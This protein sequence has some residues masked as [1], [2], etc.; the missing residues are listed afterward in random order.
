MIHQIEIRNQHASL[1]IY[2]ERLLACCRQMMLVAT[3][4]AQ[5]ELLNDTH[6]EVMLC[7]QRIGGIGTEIGRSGR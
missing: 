5:E 1:L 6:D 7:S 3:G 4:G 2:V